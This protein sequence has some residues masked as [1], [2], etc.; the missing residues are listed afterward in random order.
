MEVTVGIVCT[1][2]THQIESVCASLAS[3]PVTM[4][5]YQCPEQS[6]LVKSCSFVQFSI[7]FMFAVEDMISQRALGTVVCYASFAAMDF[8]VETY[9]KMNSF[10]NKPLWVVVF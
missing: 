5:T 6:L 4:G 8:W 10:F 2:L 3:P 9:S 1:A 7:C